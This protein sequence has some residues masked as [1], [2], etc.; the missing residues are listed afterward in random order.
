MGKAGF[1]VTWVKDGRAALDVLD[2]QDF[3]A[4]VLDLGLPKVSGIDVLRSLRARGNPI[5]VLV[6][7]AADLSLIHI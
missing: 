4:V 2:V 1:G 7:T 5:P 6:L 3:A